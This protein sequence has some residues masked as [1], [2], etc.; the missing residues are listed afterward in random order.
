MDAA[1]L[2]RIFEPFFSTKFAGR[3]LGLAAVLGIVR[4]HRGALLV[5]TAAGRGSRFRLLLP[6]RIEPASAAT[7]AT[8]GSPLDLVGR[9]ILVVDDDPSVCESIA[10]LL[11]RRGAA[12]EQVHDGESALAKVRAGRGRFDCIL[13]DLVMPEMDGQECERRLRELDPDLVVILMSGYAKQEL[14]AR[15]SGR[16][17]A[18]FLAKPFTRE[19]LTAA[20]APVLR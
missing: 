14:R 20:L 4:D 9:S 1:T 15:F 3:G 18:G 19:E 5:E 11:G 16:N 13:L 17:V 12:V 8:S 6:A 2:K 7:P 10:R